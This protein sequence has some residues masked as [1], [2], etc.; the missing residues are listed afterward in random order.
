[1]PLL[2]AVITYCVLRIIKSPLCRGFGGS[3]KITGSYLFFGALVSA[4]IT[5]VCGYFVP[6]NS[7]IIAALLIFFLTLLIRAAVMLI[8]EGVSVKKAVKAEAENNVTEI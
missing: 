1:M 5:F 8:A 4:V 3:L 7:L 2:I 6:R